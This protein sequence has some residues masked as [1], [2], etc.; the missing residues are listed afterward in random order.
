MC[1]QLARV[2]DFNMG[3]QAGLNT[4]KDEVA[5]KVLLAEVYEALEA[6]LDERLRM[7][8][9][10]LPRKEDDKFSEP[11]GKRG[12]WERE[13]RCTVLKVLM[14]KMTSHVPALRHRILV[15]AGLSV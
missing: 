2:D 3:V 14:R 11:W 7:L 12:R 9:P 13:T 10:W 4:A 8:H 15:E 6:P 1:Y 5:R